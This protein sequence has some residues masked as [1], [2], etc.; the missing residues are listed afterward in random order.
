M[1]VNELIEKYNEAKKTNRK[2][3]FSKHIKN[4]YLPYSRKIAIAKRALRAT[5]FKEVGHFEFYEQDTPI[6]ML[7]FTV[8]LIEEYTDIEF[9][10]TDNYSIEYDM[11]A[12][13]GVLEG[14]I[15]AIPEKEMDICDGIRKMVKDDFMVNTRSL[16]SF[17]ETH[18]QSWQ[19]AIDSL[20][21]QLNGNDLKSLVESLSVK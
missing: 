12:A 7:L 21:A 16:V 14:I 9:E 4:T 19:T 13:S 3:D 2:Y 17:L 10:H 5:S 6:M 15:A 20:T 11:L 18:S 8:A 1:T